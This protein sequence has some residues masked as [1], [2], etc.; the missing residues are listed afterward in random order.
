MTACCGFP[1]KD[2]LT[3]NEAKTRAR[4]LNIHKFDGVRV[5][6][7]RCPHTGHW[8]VGHVLPRLDRKRARR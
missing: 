8:H 3:R 5:V 1:E 7:Y 2:R 4:T 6:A